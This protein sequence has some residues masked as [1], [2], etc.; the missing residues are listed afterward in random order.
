M[1]KIIA[2]SRGSVSIFLCIIF[3][4]FVVLVC[5]LTEAAALRTAEIQAQRTIDMAAR[6]VL[7]EY[8]RNLK[9]EYGIFGFEQSEEQIESKIAAYAN[10]MLS[11]ANMKPSEEKAISL[12]DFNIESIS[13]EKDHLSLNNLLLFETQILEYMKYR[14]PLGYL[15]DFSTETENLNKASGGLELLNKS[16]AVF[17][18]LA[19]VD[20]LINEL[21]KN[22]DG[23][24]FNKK[25]FNL[26][27]PF[28]KSLCTQGSDEYENSLYGLLSISQKEALR[29]MIYIQKEIEEKSIS[30]LKSLDNLVQYRCTDA[31]L[32]V[33]DK[34]ISSAR[35]GASNVEAI[36]QYNEMLGVIS[37]EASELERKISKIELESYKEF[38]QTRKESC[39]AAYAIIRRLKVSVQDTRNLI[40][41]VEAYMSQYD[42]E[43]LESVSKSVRDDMNKIKG[44][45]DENAADNILSSA[46][47]SIASNRML[48]EDLIDSFISESEIEKLE[49]SAKA[50]AMQVTPENINMGEIK[51][52]IQ[53]L[54]Q[55]ADSYKQAKASY[56]NAFHL[57]L[58]Y[59]ESDFTIEPFSAEQIRELF[60]SS[61]I[62]KNYESVPAEISEPVVDKQDKTNKRLINEYIIHNLP[63]QLLSS[64]AIENEEREF[65]KILKSFREKYLNADAIRNNLY[66]NEYILTHFKSHIS[67]D[68]KKSFF[69]NETEYILYGNFSDNDNFIAFKS[70]LFLVRGGMN[71]LHIYS[72]EVK[73][74]QVMGAAAA[75]SGGVGTFLTQFLIV[76]AWAGAEA[77][78]DVEKLI[79]KEKVA[80]VKTKESWVLS[81]DNFVNGKKAAVKDNSNNEDNKGFQVNMFSYEDYLRLFLILTN[82]DKKLYRILDLVQI[83]MKGRHYRDFETGN[84]SGACHVKAAFTIKYKFL[85]LSWI[86]DKIKNEVP[87]R[88][89]LYVDVQHGY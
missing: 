27:E 88:K 4:C 69:D 47:M 56:N 18:E 38:Y 2:E 81:F 83:N 3:L 22:S 75:V 55:Q 5:V 78:Y 11:H 85:N 21:R 41:E 6:S 20:D 49:E 79:N 60:G 34:E 45:V 89:Y 10:R 19:A 36:A 23:W 63:S 74:K 31:L 14:A 57:F 35:K 68:E 51:T 43:I 37:S 52:Q 16:A 30:Y 58:N 77:G 8:D 25:E 26:Y 46:E 1:Y 42:S 86:P 70:N 71:L 67:T 82:K 80:F 53:D 7:S 17:K 39:D 64:A 72:D 9:N 29:E 84:F 15:Y 61:A 59:Y 32:D 87:K 54:V 33:L 62:N 48:L 65:T 12:Y 24:F 28:I 13:A 44:L 73:R 40:K 76:T 66:V 50:L